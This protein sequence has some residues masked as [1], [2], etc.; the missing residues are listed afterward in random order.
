MFSGERLTDS[1]G[2]SVKQQTDQSCTLWG[3]VSLCD[4]SMNNNI[5]GYIV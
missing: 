2:L 1:L 5:S 3:C 4:T